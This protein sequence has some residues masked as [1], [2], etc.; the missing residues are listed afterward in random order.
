MSCRPARLAALL[1]LLA[2]LTALAL[3]AAL[4]ALVLALLEGAVAQL[5]LAADHVA[6][7]VELAHHVVV[8]VLHLAGPRHLQV[9]EHRLQ[10]LQH[11]PGGVLGAG[12]CHLLQAVDHVLEILRA[13]LARIGIER[14]GELFRIAPHLLGQRLQELVERGAQIVGELLELFVGGAALQRLAQRF[15]RR[16]QRRFGIG[17]VAV[18]ELHR[19][20]PH[21]RRPRRAT[22]RRSWRARAAKDR[23]QAEIDV[24]LDI[25]LLR[26]HRSAHRAR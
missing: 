5:L 19:H 8:A 16:A 9:L 24:A 26:R 12:A 7:L 3:L 17:D 6:E 13:D 4:A 22:G 15:L 25:E 20:V 21:A 18:F 10:F 1:A 2:A 11:L 23:A 14:T